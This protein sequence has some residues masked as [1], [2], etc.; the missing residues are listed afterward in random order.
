MRSA[1]PS[2]E[3]EEWISELRLLLGIGFHAVEGFI[4]NLGCLGGVGVLKRDDLEISFTFR[5]LRVEPDQVL[6]QIQSLRV[7]GGDDQAVAQ[8]LN[9]NRLVLASGLLKCR[10]FFLLRIN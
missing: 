1:D 5:L 8:D 6:R 9:V 7:V 10:R 3:I 4:E 2:A